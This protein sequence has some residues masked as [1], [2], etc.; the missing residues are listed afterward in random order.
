MLQTW[1]IVKYGPY[2]SV[3]LAVGESSMLVVVVVMVVVIVIVR[4]VVIVVVVVGVVIEVVVVGVGGVGMMDGGLNS[5]IGVA[6]GDPDVAEVSRR[7]GLRSRL[8]FTAFRFN[9]SSD[10]L[11]LI[12][13][14]L[15]AAE[16]LEPALVDRV[17]TLNRNGFL[18][19]LNHR[20]GFLVARQKSGFIENRSPSGGG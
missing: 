16:S 15:L 6:R 12:L 5:G 7:L 13:N 14:K 18:N 19:C 10:A 11:A 8:Q 20:I 4:R 3:A 1:H 17:Q 9:C 2:Q